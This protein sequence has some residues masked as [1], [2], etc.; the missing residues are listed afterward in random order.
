MIFKNVRL[1]SIG[2]ALPDEV[3]SSASIEQK[4]AGLYERLRLPLGRLE[5]MTGIRERRFWSRPVTPSEASAMAGEN[6]LRKTRFARKDLDL[7]IHTSVCRDRLEPATASY[8]HRRLELT[9]RTQIFDISNACLGVLTG[10]TMAANMIELGQIGAALVVSGENSRPLMENTVA[11]LLADTTMTQQQFKD[12]FASLTIGSAAAAVVLTRDSLSRE[13]HRFLGGASI[14]NTAFSHLCQ[15]NSDAGMGDGS[16]PL[17]STD[18]EELLV[19]GVETAQAAWAEFKRELGW[20]EA[21]PD[22]VCTHQ[23][24]RVHRDRLYVGLGLDTTKDFP[25]VEFMGNC[26]SASLPATAALA[27][28]AGHL[29]PGQ[30]L[31]MLGIGSG[32]NCTMLGVEW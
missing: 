6:V 5:L 26:G 9:G 22:L 1:E 8:V 14:A 20:T 18:S 12:A 28:Q 7:L 13:K 27:I 23:V 24:G 4:L 17:M 32:I 19:R 25:T 11:H 30:R 21:T 15:G 31:A 29:R 2:Y 10:M 3:W 16:R